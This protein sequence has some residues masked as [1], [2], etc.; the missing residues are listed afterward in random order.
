MTEPLKKT[1]SLKAFTDKRDMR[2]IATLAFVH[3]VILLCGLGSSVIWTRMMSPESFG[4]FRLVLS[5]LAF[6]GGFCLLGT[7]QAAL[8]SASQGMDGN[9]NRLLAS[10]LWANL[11]GSGGLLA[12]A[13]YYWRDGNS[14][15]ALALAIAAV[16]FPSYNLSDFW[17]SWLN[18][19][20]A[21]GELST[22]RAVNAAIPVFA[23]VM[24]VLIDTRQTWVVILIL[25]LAIGVQNVTRVFR[26]RNSLQGTQSDLKVLA[27]GHHNSIAMAFSSLLALDVI[28]LERWHSPIEVASYAV[29]LQLPSSLKGLISIFGQVLAPRVYEQTNVRDAW[30]VIRRPFFALQAGFILIGLVGFFWLEPIMIFL[31]TREYSAAIELSRWLWLATCITGP[32]VYLVPLLASTKRLLFVYGPY[33]GYP[34]V[35]TCL[36]LALGSEGVSGVVTARIGAMIALAAFYVL[37]F[38]FLLFRERSSADVYG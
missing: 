22:A 14:D 5:V 20:R 38:V 25:M 9:F 6:V 21:F 4:E 30:V 27:Y 11:A 16:L 10:R 2:A 18:G 17:M 13:A 24:A 3:G 23:L 8:M 1:W 12:A 34:L 37:G 36:F 29:A 31:F 26:S 7:G 33:F 19:K 15:V 28:I 35:L 32:A